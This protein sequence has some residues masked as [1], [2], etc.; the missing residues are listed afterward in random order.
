MWNNWH[1]HGADVGD[2]DATDMTSKICLD[3]VE[4]A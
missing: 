4:Q 2:G 3:G 1:H